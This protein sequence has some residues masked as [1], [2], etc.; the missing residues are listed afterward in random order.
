MT[1]FLDRLCRGLEFAVALALAGMVVLVFGNVVLR[2]GFNS[3]ITVSEEVS[4]WLF[5]WGTFLGAVL[6]MRERAHLGMDLVV[7][8]LP[9]WG[10]RA[11]LV[12]SQAIMLAILGLL[13]K[14]GLEQAKIN[15]DVTA[16]T[17]GAPMAIIYG[18]VLVFAAL[19]ALMLL[20][21]LAKAAAGRMT[22]DELV[23]VQGSEEDSQVR[24][25]L[26]DATSEGT[27]P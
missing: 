25:I 15:W 18:A 10:R 12:A 9:A 2:Y 6:A 11:C 26:A 13:F 17:T 8:R 27:G 4:R 19:A 21:D 20:A 3:G 7:S 16:P 1:A 5:I 23:M 22:D 24:R 14:G